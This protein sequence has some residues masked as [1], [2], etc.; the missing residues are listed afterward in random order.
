MLCWH[1]AGHYVSDVYDVKQQR[2]YSYNDSDV[3]RTSEDI[4]RKSR[5]RCGYI[6]FYLS[7]WVA[8]QFS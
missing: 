4:V 2:W 1:D 5:E 7:K 8:R 6:F 3:M